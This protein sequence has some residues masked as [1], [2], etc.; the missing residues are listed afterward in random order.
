MP[1]PQL[2]GLL[3]S[4]LTSI[5]WKQKDKFMFYE[6]VYTTW[7]MFAVEK[8]SFYYE[9]GDQKGTATLGDLV[10]CPPGTPFRRVIITPLT[11]YYFELSWTATQTFGAAGEEDIP[12][13]KISIFDTARLEQ[14]YATMR[15]WQSWPKEV[16]ISKNTHYCRDMWLLYCDGLEEGVLPDEADK[17]QPQDPLMREARQMISQR[18]FTSLNLKEIA[19]ALGIT[20]MQLTKKF[21][22]A[23]GVTPVRYLTSLRL[24]KAKTLLIETDLTIEQISECC[25]YQNGFYLTRIFA[26]YEH[27]TP[28]HYRKTY[29]V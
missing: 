1:K 20:P 7:V 18:A 25:G 6:D 29:R 14:N 5:Y 27:T 9:I 22:A 28:S 13:G 24:T 19:S 21:S 4:V 26:K 16:Y 8:G 17:G 2:S 3:P 11:F 23:F 12:F 15:K 10:L